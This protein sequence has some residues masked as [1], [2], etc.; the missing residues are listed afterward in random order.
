MFTLSPR[1]ISRKRA[2]FLL[3]ISLFTSPLPIRYSVARPAPLPVQPTGAPF[4]RVLNLPVNDIIYDKHSKKLFASLPSRVG[5]RGNA[6]IEIDPVTGEPGTAAFVGSEPNKLAISDDGQVIYVGLDGAAAIRRVEVASHT[7]TTQFSVGS[8]PGNGTPFRAGDLAVVPGNPNA[9]AVARV[10]PGL[11]PPGKGVAVFD[12]G[13]QRPNIAP[14]FSGPSYI[15]FGSNASTLFGSV[16]F[17]GSLQKMTVDNSGVTSVGSGPANFTGELQFEN[18]F[19]YNERGQVYNPASDSVVGAFANA[20]FGPFV[21]DATVGRAY[22]ITNAQ[23]HGS[24]PIVL[25]AYDLNTFAQLGEISIGG[26]FGTPT[27]LVRWGTNGLAFRTNGDQVFLVQTALIPSPDPIPDPTPTPTPTPSP[28]PLPSDAS[29]RHVPLV[30]NDVAYVASSQA[31]YASVPSVAGPSGNSVAA[32]DPVA[33]TVGVPVFV[34]SEPTKL[35]LADDGHSLYVGLNG[36]NAVRRFDTV[37]QTPGLQFSLGTSPPN[38]ISDGFFSASDLAVMPGSPNTIAVCRISST[39]NP[40]TSLSVYDDGI[41]R[42]NDSNGVGREIEFSSSPTRIYSS[43][44]GGSSGLQRNIVTAAGV[45]LESSGPGTTGS[46]KFANGRIYMS[47]GPVFD[48]ESGEL[49][50][51]FFL[52]DTGSNPVLMTVDVALGRAYFFVVPSGGQGRLNVYDINTFLQL[53]S[54]P[55]E[56]KVDQIEGLSFEYSS[57]IRWG[58]NGLAF[59]TTS[60]VT[61]IQSA[62]VGPGTVPAPTPTPSPTPSPSPTPQLPTFIRQVDLPARDIVFNPAN[63]LLY[64]SVSG[65]ASGGRADSITSIDPATG[66]FGTSVSTG[67]GTEPDKLALSDNGQVI[68]LGYNGI[69]TSP[70]G[71]GAI[72]RYD[73]ATQTLGPDISLGTEPNFGSKQFAY[74][75]AFAPGNPNL[76]AVARYSSGS[77][78]QQ[79]VAIFDNGVQR[80]NTTPGHTQG[81]VSVAFSSAGTLYGGSTETGLKTIAVDANGATVT[82]T[83]PFVFGP[84]VDFRNGLLY[85][86]QGQ[87]LNPTTNTL[88][89]SFNTSVTGRAMVIDTALNRAFFATGNDIG[90]GTTMTITAYDLN[91]FVPIG[92]ITL[93]FAGVPT[94]LVR[95]GVNGLALRSRVSSSSGF[96]F[97]NKLYILQ[98]ALVSNAAPIPTGVSLSTPTLTVSENNSSVTFTVNR[99][100]DLSSPSSVDYATTDGSASER[101]DYTTALGTLRFAPGE[102][103]KT[104]Q[105]FLTNDVHQESNETFSLNISNPSG[106]ELTSPVSST[107]TIQDNDFAPTQT[108]PVDGTNFFVRQHYRDF[109]NRNP[110]NPGLIF[111]SNEIDQCGADVQCREV[112]RINVSA[113]FFLSIEF[114]NTGYLVYLLRQASFGTRETLEMREFLR[115]TQEIG[116]GIIVG[117]QDWEAQLETN[118]RNFI[119][120]FVALPQFVAAH[121]LS[122]TPTQF[123]DALNANT[124]DPTQPTSGGSLTQVERDQL[125][126]ELTSGVKTRADVVR[127]IADN[128]LFRQRQF[129]RAFVYM[130]YVG[131]L[132]RNPNATPD[133]DF[134]GYNFWLNKLNNFNGNFVDAEM[135]KAF[136]SSGEYRMRFAP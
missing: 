52:G 25:R 35:A 50:G 43:G 103:S 49:K 34:G 88:L 135:V 127:A 33:G 109:L 104:I 89:G 37:T 75:I 62:L 21:V 86:G 101:G 48:A 93:P 2:A 12:N 83:A 27:S 63:N 24:D 40:F 134:A 110:D 5:A 96:G 91:T 51:T 71:P 113:A 121:P 56:Y 67:A 70:I 90:F 30:T 31:I 7:A 64:A 84:N 60:H 46:I 44:P 87:V 65:S 118:K 128:S 57:L 116:Q 28:S 136:L 97:D 123:V 130:Q 10:Q 36:A 59:R 129:N 132:R 105:V 115:D 58:Q 108:N 102:T 111:W 72:R 107:V 53:G 32:V 73:V 20:G 9:V 15:A 106:A 1:I 74:D 133:S 68:Y 41:K 81:S 119:D 100:G 42:A 26:V 95:W 45:A 23:T 98:T 29:V 18:G 82:N 47:N 117:S 4:V 11:S 6:V 94:R 17:S 19:L 16:L 80:P 55:I 66:T 126:A 131:Y 76:I 112:K 124:T 61:I 85:S 114:Q 92:R 120:R 77:P 14:A 13:V 39:F 99:T 79:G 22:Y 3:L 78:P 122:L 38:P 54:T 69:N 125:I 8:E